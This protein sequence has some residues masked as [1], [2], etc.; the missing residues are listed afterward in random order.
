MN[1][2]DK[3]KDSVS[4][5]FKEKISFEGKP[6]ISSNEWMI[7]AEK[8]DKDYLE[9]YANISWI[10]A[11]I[12]AIAEDV[13]TIEFKLNKLKPNDEVESVDRHEIL[14]VLNRVNDYMTKSDLIKLHQIYM[15]TTGKSFWYLLLDGQG[16]PQEIYILRPDLMRVIPNEDIRDGLIKEY[17]YG[18]KENEIIFDPEE[19]MFFNNPDPMDIRGGVGSVQPGAYAGDTVRYAQ[20]WN[21]NF[22][23]NNAMPD[24]LLTI[25]GNLQEEQKERIRRDWENKF[26]GSKK[27]SRLAILE[28]EAKLQELGLKQKDIEFLGGLAWSRDEIMALN[29]IPRSVLGI[30]DDV[31]RANA[32]ATEWIFAKRNIKPKM[33]SIVDQLNKSFVAMFDDETLF[34]DYGDPTPEDRIAKSDYYQKAINVWMTVN[35][36]RQELGLDEIEGGDVLYISANQL[37]RGETDQKAIKLQAKKSS[38]ISDYAKKYIKTMKQPEVEIDHT[39]NKLK[40]VLTNKL[41]EEE[42][43]YTNKLY[44]ED[45]R[46]AYWKQK[47][48]IDKQYEKVIEEKTEKLMEE[49][50]ADILG[51]VQQQKSPERKKNVEDWMFDKGKYKELYASVLK[52][53]LTELIREVGTNT[54]MFMGYNMILDTS[55]HRIQKYLSLNAP[56]LADSIVDTQYEKVAKA[57]KEGVQEGEGAQLLARRVESKFKDLKRYQSE[58]IARTEVLRASNKATIEA[59]RETNVVAG[60]EWLT[61]RDDR[62]CDWCDPM[63]GKIIPDSI[64]KN[65]FNK[66]DEYEVDGQTMNL[67]YEGVDGPPLHPNCRCTTVPVIKGDEVDESQIWNRDQHTKSEKDDITKKIEE[68]LDELKNIDVEKMIGEKLDKL[69]DKELSELREIKQKIDEQIK[70]D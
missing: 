23:F 69:A 14:D 40:S 28:G 3:I 59:Y 25:Q 57:L 51:R 42:E 67:S 8:K 34:L 65:F 29:K 66:G 31:N 39:K 70:E 10:Y 61:S 45:G 24:S 21:R 11:C 18:P 64:D 41:K 30:T 6:T 43:K 48:S 44:T 56:K 5:L 17:R 16:K 4:S 53:V 36:A 55:K 9:S 2:L 15:L 12:S 33:E 54:L 1:L 50:Q 46:T 22:F 58:R 37:E 38:N 19:I 60:K 49:Q 26:G 7:P 13:S 20:E 62:V 27:K 68:R 32:E 35:E 47:T 52:P 63:D